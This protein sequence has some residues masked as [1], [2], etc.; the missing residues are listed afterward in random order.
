MTKNHQKQPIVTSGA[1]LDTAETAV[2]LV[3]GRD[4]S[5]QKIIQAT[6]SLPQDQ[7][8]YLA[9]QAADASWYPNSFLASIESNEPG[10]SS[11]MRAVADAVNKANNAD[12]PTDH[13]VVLGFSQGACIA[14]EYVAHNP[15]RYG[16]LVSLSGGLMGEFT[17]SGNYDGDVES[18][19]VF[20]GSS[21]VDP[22]MPEERVHESAAVFERL[23]G[24]VTKRLY[25]GADHTITEDELDVTRRM[26]AAL[27]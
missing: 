14:S 20:F 1:P 3:H 23:N 21:D 8:A 10:R 15:T 9:P 18:T 4:R 13:V 27:L 16:G 7:V 2:V 24:D 25:D 17:D 6:A 11:G 22:Y 5:P 12:I 19:P 26:I